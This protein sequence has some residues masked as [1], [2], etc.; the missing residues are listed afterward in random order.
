AAV[1][2]LYQGCGIDSAV[3]LQDENLVF[4]DKIAVRLPA[5][6]LRSARAEG[7]GCLPGKS[8]PLQRLKTVFERRRALHSRSGWRS[9]HPGPVASVSPT[10]IA[11]QCWITAAYA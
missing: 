11:D 1:R 5:D 7:I 8:A 2:M 4:V 3:E 6:Y 10:S 9:E